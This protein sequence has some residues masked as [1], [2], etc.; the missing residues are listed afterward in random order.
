MAKQVKR[1]TQL[2]NQKDQSEKLKV[3]IYTIDQTIR[4]FIVNTIQPIVE[5]QNQQVVVPVIYADGQR[6]S[7]AKKYQLTRDKNGQI[8]SP[9]IIFKRQDISRRQN[10]HFSKMNL[11]N[12]VFNYV[13][14][15][16]LSPQSTTSVQQPIRK[17]CKIVFPQFISVSYNFIMWTDYMLQMNRLIEN[18]I[19]YANQYWG[20]DKFK[21]YVEI[22]NF[23]NTVQTG[24]NQKR[25]VK[26]EFSMTLKGHIIPQ[27][28][29][30]VKSKIQYSKNKFKINE[31]VIQNAN[32]YKYNDIIMQQYL[33]N[34]NKFKPKR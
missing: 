32:I 2:S 19:Y 28:F 22:Q 26:S 29:N 33:M 25:V 18:F 23:S 13:V 14:S 34:V 6:W 11:Q 5:Y 20:D 27:L 15:E 31:K 17:Y 10:L 3:N 9:V 24:D 8:L 21:F 1:S 4:N 7:Y 30:D 16:K 12:P